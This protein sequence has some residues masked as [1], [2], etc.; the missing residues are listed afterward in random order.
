M[1]MNEFTN[2]PFESTLE[3]VATLRDKSI[4]SSVA[5]QR[6]HDKFVIETARLY[7]NGVPVCE[8]SDASGLT[9]EQ[10]TSAASD[11]SV[12]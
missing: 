1:Q 3:I 11:L 9:V 8:L 10:I 6:E 2:S 12:S 4:R 7:R 5:A